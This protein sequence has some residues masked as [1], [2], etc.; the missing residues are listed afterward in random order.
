M[1]RS[2]LLLG[3]NRS[4]VNETQSVGSAQLFGS[5]IVVNNNVTTSGALLIEASGTP[6]STITEGVGVTLATTGSGGII[7][8]QGLP[9]M[10]TTALNIST[11]NLFVVNGALNLNN[12]F[13]GN[14]SVSQQLSISPLTA[15][16]LV[17]TS[18][19]SSNNLFVNTLLAAAGNINIVTNNG[20]I[21]VGSAVELQ[22]STGTVI[23]VP[24][25]TDGTK[26]GPAGTFAPVTSSGGSITLQDNDLTGSGFIN[27]GTNVI[28][29]TKA[30]LP[31]TGQVSIVIGAVPLTGLAAGA[32]AS[33]NPTINSTSGGGQDIL[34][35][36]LQPKTDRSRRLA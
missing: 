7:I 23:M 2:L 4:N 32:Q 1:A 13:A 22:T 17:N 24:A 19:S 25:G 14:V 16:T 15:L 11:G 20:G 33:P 26:V 5:N 29:A 8:G 12:N 6:L 36:N 27:L 35:D 21:F 3:I 30:T 9:T 10:P 31:T 18:G 34:Y 28:I